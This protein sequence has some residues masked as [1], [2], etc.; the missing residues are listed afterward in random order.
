MEEREIKKF[1]QG[2]EEYQ[3]IV[4]AE[5]NLYYEKN[6]KAYLKSLKGGKK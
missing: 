2:L 3:F 6:I 1:M 5:G 4:E